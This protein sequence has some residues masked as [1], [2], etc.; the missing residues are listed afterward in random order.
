MARFKARKARTVPRKDFSG[1]YDPVEKLM[2]AWG[3]STRRP[4]SAVDP[5]GIRE[6]ISKGLEAWNVRRVGKPN[7]Y[8]LDGIARQA[9]FLPQIEPDE[10]DYD[11]LLKVLYQR[12]FEDVA[13]K[14]SNFFGAKPVFFGNAM[15]SLKKNDQIASLGGFESYNTVPAEEKPYVILLFPKDLS[16]IEQVFEDLSHRAVS[17]SEVHKILSDTTSSLYP[18]VSKK[19][20]VTRKSILAKQKK[21]KAKKVDFYEEGKKLQGA[22]SEE[23]LDIDEAATDLLMQGYEHRKVMAYHHQVPRGYWDDVDQVLSDN[24][25]MDVSDVYDMLEE[26][27]DFHP[28][29][30]TVP[31]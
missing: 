28:D 27:Y 10:Y 30:R 17:F 20:E 29:D 7:P 15:E 9:S 26:K 19:N 3:K 13:R 22:I 31:Q 18:S 11:R 23:N 2:S 14:L 24:D 8:L 12:Q 25:G 1:D 21:K 6:E 4:E 5:D 16:E